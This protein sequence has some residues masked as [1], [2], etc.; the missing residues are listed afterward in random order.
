MRE[1][2]DS[3]VDY[4]GKRQTFMFLLCTALLRG[5]QKI[6]LNGGGLVPLVKRERLCSAS[7]VVTLAGNHRERI[8][9]SSFR[10]RYR[11]LPEADKIGL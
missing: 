4:D 10:S 6:C 11:A 3:L 2:P 5:F 9:E 1:R 7:Y 8:G